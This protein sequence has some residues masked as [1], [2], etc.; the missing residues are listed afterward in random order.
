LNWNEDL[1]D[2][3]NRV[4]L[5]AEKLNGILASMAEHYINYYKVQ[6]IK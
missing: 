6:T 3:G 2:S 1:S 4:K 5:T